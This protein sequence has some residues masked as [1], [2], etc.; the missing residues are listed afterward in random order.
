[1]ELEKYIDFI[2]VGNKGADFK[3]HDDGH[4]YMGKVATEIIRKTDLNCMFMKC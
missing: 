2:F 4:Q 1:M 3:K